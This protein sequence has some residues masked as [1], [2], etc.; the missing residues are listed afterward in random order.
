MFFS[1]VTFVSGRLW[2]VHPV[3]V[4]ARIIVVANVFFTCFFMLSLTV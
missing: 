1:G 2:N 4:R 3:R